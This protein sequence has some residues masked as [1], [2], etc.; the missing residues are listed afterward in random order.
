M[1]L[2]IGLLVLFFLWM[3]WTAY[4]DDEH[5]DDGDWIESHRSR[6]IQRGLVMV[7][8]AQFNPVLIL[9][10]FLIFM[11]SFD[12]ILNWKRETKDPFFLGNTAKWDRFWKTRPR[13]VYIFSLFVLNLNGFVIY[14]QV[15]RLTEY[16][17]IQFNKFIGFFV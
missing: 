7:G 4:I 2:K 8:F 11:G 6:V 17:A 5:L 16:F 9:A 14:F 10:F 1:F 3:Y 15:E 12:L 13:W